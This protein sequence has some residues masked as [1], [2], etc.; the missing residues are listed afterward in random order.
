[1]PGRAIGVHGILNRTFVMAHLLT[2]RID[3][4]ERATLEA[5]DTW[6]PGIESGVELVRHGIAA[7]LRKLEKRDAAGLK[8]HKDDVTHRYLPCELQDVLKL[9]PALR[10]TFVLR[11][12]AEFSLEQCAELLGCSESADKAAQ[13]AA[14]LL[15]S[16]RGMNSKRR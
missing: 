3:S 5:I 6:K 16:I 10:Q 13:A 15:P 11:F 9:R 12:L 2:G 8:T 7:A 4:A 14:R 1:M